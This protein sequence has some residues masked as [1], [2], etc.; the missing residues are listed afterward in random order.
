MPLTNDA[1][2]P[3]NKYKDYGFEAA[4]GRTSL[5]PAPPGDVLTALQNLF[6]RIR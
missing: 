4:I 2:N 3:F 5:V 6:V 1:D